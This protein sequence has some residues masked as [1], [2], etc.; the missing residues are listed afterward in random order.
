MRER[1]EKERLQHEIWMILQEQPFNKGRF[2]ALV[3]DYARLRV[4]EG[5]PKSSVYWSAGDLIATFPKDVALAERFW[6]AAEHAR[7]NEQLAEIAVRHRRNLEECGMLAENEAYRSDPNNYTMAGRL[8]KPRFD[9]PGE[10][11]KIPLR[12]GE[13]LVTGYCDECKTEHMFPKQAPGDGQQ[14]CPFDGT[15]Y[16]EVPGYVSGYGCPCC[17]AISFHHL[18]VTPEEIERYEQRIAG[19]ST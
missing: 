16:R 6:E 3:E 8:L 9:I 14:L 10:Y 12:E 7:T 19:E 1:T 5:E 13:H 18:P 2:C 15:K 4:R 11:R 17:K